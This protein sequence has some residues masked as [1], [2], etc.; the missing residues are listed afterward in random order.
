MITTHDKNY[1]LRPSPVASNVEMIDQKNKPTDVVSLTVRIL[2]IIFTKHHNQIQLDELTQN[3]E[4]LKQEVTVLRQLNERTTTAEEP[5]YNKLF[6]TYLRV[7]HTESC[8]SIQSSQCP[9]LA[10]SQ[11]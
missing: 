7:V 5:M 1:K 3:F 9:K 8:C 10:I 2:Q 4:K 11:R 6:I